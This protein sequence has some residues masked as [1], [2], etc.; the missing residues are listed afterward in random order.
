MTFGNV[1]GLLIGMAMVR[2]VL[3]RSVEH[4]LVAGVLGIL[5][6]NLWNLWRNAS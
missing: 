3:G 6:V 4:T 2:F 1:V 5:F